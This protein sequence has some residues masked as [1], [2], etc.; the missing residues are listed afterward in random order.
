MLERQFAG[1]SDDVD[2]V[3]LTQR[4]QNV[5]HGGFLAPNLDLI[6]LRDDRRN[7]SQ[8]R[9]F[10]RRLEQIPKATLESD[11]AWFCVAQINSRFRVLA[12]DQIVNIDQAKMASIAT[13]VIECSDAPRRID[14]WTAV[15]HQD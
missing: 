12:V 9:D 10:E 3:A 11:L 8:T 4:H 14:V 2:A 13:T 5:I 6:W 7:H 15:R 1:A